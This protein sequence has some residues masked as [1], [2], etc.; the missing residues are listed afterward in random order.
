MNQELDRLLSQ[1]GAT[2]FMQ[3]R[4]RFMEPGIAREMVLSDQTLS[5]DDALEVVRAARRIISMGM[6]LDALLL[7]KKGGP[8]KYPGIPQPRAIDPVS[9]SLVAAGG[10]LFAGYLAVSLWS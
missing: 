1:I 2:R 6:S 8:G 3:Y 9:A 10:L 7:A 4:K 5:M